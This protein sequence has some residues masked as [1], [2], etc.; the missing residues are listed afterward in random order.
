MVLVVLAIPLFSMRLGQLDAGTN[1]PDSS[2]RKAYDLVA[3]GFGPGANGPFTVVVDVAQ[4]GASADQALLGSLQKALGDDP[5][6]AGVTPPV[7]NPSGDTAV[8]TVVPTTAPSD[9][10][11]T[12]LIEHLRS[13]VLAEQQVPTY[14]TGTTAAYVDFTNRVADR[15]PYLIAGVVVLALLLLTAA[16]RSL[17]IGIKAA[18]MNLLSVGAAY[19]VVVAVF[20]YGW[21]SSLVGIHETLPIPSFVPMLMFALVFGLSM[22]YEVFLLSRVH[23]AYV[24]T[25]DEHRAVAIGIG[26][27]ARVITTAAA[28]M[29]VVFTSFVLS[30]D[31]TVKM[32]AV[33]MASAVLIDASIVR[34]ILVPSV[35]TLLGDRAWWIPGW[36]D[37][38]LPD[39]QLESDG[40]A[41]HPEADVPLVAPREAGA[42]EPAAV[43]AVPRRPVAPEDDR[44]V[45]R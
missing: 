10:A 40:P 2:S 28:I 19:G 33:G 13:D 29:I 34:M 25:G 3:Q 31:P 42:A 21:G 5:G 22:D 12:A 36:L 14:L 30:D 37:R 35:M 8:M 45:S 44:P 39:F 7:V 9:A 15:L 27:T 23:E 1:P 4:Q 16:F 32:F 18:A 26:A 24:E 38:V 6:V 41:P 11:T 17:A 43:P 20:Q